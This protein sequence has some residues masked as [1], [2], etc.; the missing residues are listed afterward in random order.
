MNGI[1][2]AT[3]IRLNNEKCKIIFLTSSPEY[4][5]NSYKVNAF[6]YLI[7]PLADIERNNFV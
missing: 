2:L 6:Y 5:V 4:A 7:K 3:E 1:E